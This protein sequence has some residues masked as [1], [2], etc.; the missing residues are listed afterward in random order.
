MLLTFVDSQSVKG[1]N[2]WFSRLNKSKT[3]AR[4]IISTP[5]NL[6]PQRMGE[7]GA[8]N[9]T[10]LTYTY[11][12]YSETG[13]RFVIN[14]SNNISSLSMNN[15]FFK[16]HLVASKNVPILHAVGTSLSLMPSFPHHRLLL[17]R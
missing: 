14:P 2:F 12:P 11:L 7:V 3:D 5:N 9:L 8:S 16:Y 17:I 1:D 6:T 10:T 15:S 4:F 13:V